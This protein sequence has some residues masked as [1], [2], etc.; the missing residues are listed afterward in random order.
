MPDRSRE[1]ALRGRGHHVIVGVDE[2]GKG[3]WAGP[4]AVGMAVLP[5]DGELPGVRDSKSIS[6]KRR[7]AIFAD[8]AEWCDHWS[9]GFAS[10]A[11]CDELGMAA[12]QRLATRRALAELGVTPDAA[13]VDGNWD[14]V[15]PLVG[16]VEMIVKGD[17]SCLSI[18][19]ASILAKVTRDRE[20]RRLADD[21]PYWNLE[22]N[23]GYPCQ[24]HRVALQGHGPSAIHRRSWSFMDS[25][26]PWPGVHRV[27]RAEPPTLF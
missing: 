25:F 5:T 17:Q 24:W 15:S 9:V 12:A 27:A 4:L 2:V 10:P 13:V 18:A 8:V 20:M 16:A 3:S 22:S 11:E 7:E 1:L 14:F 19:A 6:E 23:K 26:V 21:Y